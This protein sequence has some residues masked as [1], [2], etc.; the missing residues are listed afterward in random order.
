VIVKKKKHTIKWNFLNYNKLYESHSLLDIV[1][2][3]TLTF[4]VCYQR[5]R[6]TQVQQL[7]QFSKAVSVVFWVLPTIKLDDPSQVVFNN[8]T[9]SGSILSSKRKGE[10]FQVA[11]I[12][13]SNFPLI[14]S[15]IYTTTIYLVLFVPLQVWNS[16]YTNAKWLRPRQIRWNI[17]DFKYRE[18]PDYIYRYEVTLCLNFCYNKLWNSSKVSIFFSM[19]DPPDIKSV[20]GIPKRH[21]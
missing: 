18:I 16:A 4:I 14:S 13:F 6:C 10:Q 1:R 17:T 20:N 3:R 21:R 12:S 15:V 2:K 7:F 8:S 19:I 5:N 9:K 11:Y